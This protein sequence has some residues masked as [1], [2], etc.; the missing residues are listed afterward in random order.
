MNIHW[1]VVP[2]SVR[3]GVAKNQLEG[4]VSAGS[5]APFPGGPGM[6]TQT[7][8]ENDAC[9]HGLRGMCMCVCLCGGNRA[10]FPFPGLDSLSSRVAMEVNWIQ[11]TAGKGGLDSR[12]YSL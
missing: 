7:R 12:G 5:L 11:S 1:E 4:V 9:A 8:F 10:L 6:Q 3:G 2:G